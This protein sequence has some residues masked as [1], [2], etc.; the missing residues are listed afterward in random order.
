M[1]RS[2]RR[3]LWNSILKQSRNR[4][5]GA[6]I[7]CRRLI[8]SVRQSVDDVVHLTCRN[9][10][11]RSLHNRNGFL[12]GFLFSKENADSIIDFDNDKIS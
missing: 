5:T 1:S 2:R 6:G 3:S 9:R 12:G 8:R 4:K 11:L 10:R 7:Q